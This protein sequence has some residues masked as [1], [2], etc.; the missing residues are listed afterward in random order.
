MTFDDLEKLVKAQGEEIISLNQELDRYKEFISIF[1]DK[2]V[3]NKKVQFLQK[4]YDKNDGVVTE[5]NP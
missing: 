3:F 1:S 2:I 5:I 4:V